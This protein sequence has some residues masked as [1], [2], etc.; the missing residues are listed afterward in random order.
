MYKIKTFIMN[1]VLAVTLPGQ[2]CDDIDKVINDWLYANS[3]VAEI[4]NITISTINDNCSL[5]TVFYKE[6]SQ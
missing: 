4:K 3:A 6:S 1:T 2:I 5:V